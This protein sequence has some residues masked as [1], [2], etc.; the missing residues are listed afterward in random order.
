[1]E[2]IYIDCNII[3]DWLTDREPFSVYA[4]E[5]F[6]LI[7]SRQVEGYVSPLALA[8]TYY[9]LTKHFNKKIAYEFLNDCQELFKII[10]L[11][12]DIVI[13]AINNKYKDFEDDLHYYTARKNKI[14][15]IITRNKKDFKT[16]E[17]KILTAEEY[18]TYYKKKR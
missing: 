13:Q 8:N 1:M 5:L 3:I 7:E 14:K 12:K 15:Y 4:D 2:K 6:T 18:I 10:D 9:L 11:S 17:E 16:Q